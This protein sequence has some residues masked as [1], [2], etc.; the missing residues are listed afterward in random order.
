M[1]V[2]LATT[3]ELC[4]VEVSDDFLP[5]TKSNLSLTRHNIALLSDFWK[6]CAEAALRESRGALKAVYSEH[7]DLIM[8]DWED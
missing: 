8:Q 7:K 6:A 1:R 4:E 3:M 2:Y 5:V